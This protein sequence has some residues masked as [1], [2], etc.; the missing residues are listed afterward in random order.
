MN[1]IARKWSSVGSVIQG[2]FPAPL[3]GHM[4]GS[5]AEVSSWFTA[6][7]TNTIDSGET[8]RMRRLAWTI[9]VHKCYNGSF[10]TTQLK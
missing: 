8:S 10:S 7:E 1:R 3:S 4:F 6:Y 9:A 2:A 5:L